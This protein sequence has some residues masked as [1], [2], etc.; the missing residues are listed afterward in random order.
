MLSFQDRISLH[1]NPTAVALLQL[2]ARKKSNLSVAV[3]VTSKA[4]LLQL[5]EKLGPY[6]CVLKTHIDIVE[7]FDSDLVLQ[8]K[9]LAAKHD[10]LI[11]EDRKF[12]DIGNTVKLQYSKGIYRIA[13]WADITNAHPIPGDGIVDGLKD[14]GLPLG[15]GLLILAE[16]SSAGTLA[17]GSYTVEAVKMAQ[18]HSDFCIGFIGQN[19]LKTLSSG[20]AVKQDFI[21]MTPGDSMGQQYR[22]PRQVI[23][24]GDSDII[25]VGRGIYGSGDV[26]QNA[27]QYRKAG[28][29]AYLEKIGQAE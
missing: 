18:R 2:M 15:R 24:E 27:I 9:A 1:S 14:V 25:I 6:I 23:V 16:M 26:V 12:A 20:E 7:D 5:A 29:D 10:F 4:E 19:R 28:W 13:E 22:T 11:F 21:Y 17:A 3:D 8:L